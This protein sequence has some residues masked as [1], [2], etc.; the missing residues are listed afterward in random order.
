[1][2]EVV[3][4]Q[5]N[6]EVPSLP[7]PRERVTKKASNSDGF[8]FIVWRDD[9]RGRLYEE[10]VICAIFTKGVFYSNKETTFTYLLLLRI[11]MKGNSSPRGRWILDFALYGANSTSSGVS[12]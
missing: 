11:Q 7:P 5:R 3:S 2:S 9:I 1:M 6:T 10:K 4:V 8:H 12:N